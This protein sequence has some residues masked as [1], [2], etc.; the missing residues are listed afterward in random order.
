[1]IYL[2]INLIFLFVLIKKYF[3]NKS[4]QNFHVLFCI[5]F[6]YIKNKRS[7]NIKLYLIKIDSFY[8]KFLPFALFSRI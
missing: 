1:M 8:L 5:K 4:P 2:E 6:R 7:L 3:L